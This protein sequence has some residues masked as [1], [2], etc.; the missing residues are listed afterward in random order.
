MSDDNVIPLPATPQEV[1]LANDPLGLQE[2]SKRQGFMVGAFSVRT[3]ALVAKV[4][5]D[6]LN[7]LIRGIIPTHPL[8]EGGPTTWGG[9]TTDERAAIG[10]A[11]ARWYELA[12]ILSTKERQWVEYFAPKLRAVELTGAGGSDLFGSLT[13]TE[14]AVRVGAI[15]DA[16][17]AR[18]DGRS[19]DD[20]GPVG[21]DTGASD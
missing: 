14:R 12:D 17:R 13:D 2:Y 7:D 4:L 3:M 20:G 5:D 15:L 18:R 11:W 9:P 16:G 8:F 19:P 6:A 1:A 21:S 10:L